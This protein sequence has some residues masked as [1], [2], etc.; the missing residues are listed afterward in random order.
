MKKGIAVLFMCACLLLMGCSFPFGGTGR[1]E[2]MAYD[3]YEDLYTDMIDLTDGPMYDPSF[4][5]LS[6][7]VQ[8]LHVLAIFNMEIENGGLCQFFANGGTA[9]ASLVADCLRQIGAEDAVVLYEG[10]LRKY[11]I[12]VQNLSAFRV[13]TVEDYIGLTALYP[14]D[15]FD[16]PYIRL[17]EDVWMRMITFANENI[18]QL[19]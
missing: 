17:C 16:E 5:K 1:E 15:E 13:Q 10:F 9:Y 4:E 12:D 2:I 6:T 3:N 7:E 14:Y 18:E 19:H 8:T 11:Q